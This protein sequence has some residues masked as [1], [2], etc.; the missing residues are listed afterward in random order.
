MRLI[1]GAIPESRVVKIW[2]NCLAGRTDLVTEEDGPVEVVYPGRPN[3]DRGADLKDCVITVGRRLRRGDVEVHVM[4]SS[5]WG[6]G[7]HQDPV[8]N[9]VILHVVY[10]RDT[11]RAVV[12]QDG[13]NVPTLTLSRY[14]AG[15]AG[16]RAGIDNLDRRPLP[17]RAVAG[18]RGGGFLGGVLDGAGDLRFAARVAEFRASLSR[19]GPAQSLYEGI[20]GALGYVKNKMPMLELASR[21][22]LS[23]LAGAAPAGVPDEECL[24]RYQALLLGTA[25]LLPPGD[26]EW[27]QRLKRTWESSGAGETMSAGDWRSFKVRPGNLPRR[28]LAAM[29]YLLLRYRDEGLLAGLV[30]G[31]ENAGTETGKRGLEGSLLVAA[32]DYWAEN[33]DFGLPARGPVPAL[34]G[35][36]RAGIIVVN[37]LLP[38]AAAWGRPALAELATETYHRY[39]ALAENAPERHVR[40]QLGVSRLLVNSARRQQGLLHLFKTLCSQGMCGECPLG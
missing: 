22:P 31:L 8:Y 7:H 16:R 38:F 1:A 11:D 29:S 13:H 21:L 2:Q 20:F 25:G 35:E 33:L 28:R 9:R 39:H 19:L 40:R 12:R 4:S 37:V 36:D 6:H 17:C 30:R 14:V 5:W 3:D 23:R 32:S 24:A 18:R 26:E 15:A 10:Q 34:L 27:T